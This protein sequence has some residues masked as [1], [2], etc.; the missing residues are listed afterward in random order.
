MITEQ[1][2]KFEDNLP[3]KPFCTDELQYGLQ[4]RSKNIAISRRYVQ[5]NKPTSVK[6]LAFDIDYAGVTEHIRN[7]YLPPPNLIAYNRKSGRSH[8]FYCLGVEVYTVQN[9]R[10]KPLELLAAIESQLCTELMADQGYTGLI[11]KNPLH[12][13]WEVQELRQQPWD[14][15]EFLEYL[16][17]PK[18]TERKKATYGLGRNVFLFDNT[19]FWAYAQ[20]LSYRLAGAKDEFFKAVFNYAE[21]KNQQFPAPLSFPE[22]Q[23]TAKSIA[24]W[25][26]KNYTGRM[27]DDEFGRVQ[28]KRGSKSGTARLQKTFE[29]RVM[30]NLYSIMGLGQ[31]EIANLLFTTQK[32]VSVWCKA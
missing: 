23:A 22:V 9:A 11:C 16:K 15:A 24:K 29:Q 8:V 1:L 6:Y 14:L 10:R 7:N 30:A 19:R 31:K 2:K 25:T 4:I 20:V 17:L 13:A 12:E 32:T 28:A 5:H 3:K 27:T 26:W 21:Q 18:K